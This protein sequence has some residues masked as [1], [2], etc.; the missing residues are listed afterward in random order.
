MISCLKQRS[1]IFHT[2]HHSGV[3]AFR[4][5]LFTDLP[6]KFTLKV[7]GSWATHEAHIPKSATDY[8]Y[9]FSDLDI[10]TEREVDRFC[11]SEIKATIHNVAYK[12]KI[13]LNN[14]SVRKAV[15]IKELWNI[16]RYKIQGLDSIDADAFLGFW[17]IIGAI[18]AAILEKNC[19]GHPTSPTS[20][21]FA[22]FFLKFLNNLCVI[23]NYF[24]NCYYSAA[25][26]M[27]RKCPSPE[28]FLAYGVKT[29]AITELSFDSANQLLSSEFLKILHSL[30]RSRETEQMIL[31]VFNDVFKWHV[32]RK[33][34]PVDSY[35]QI[36]YDL[37]TSELQKNVLTRAYQKFHCRKF[38]HEQ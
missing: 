3:T 27:S 7:S 12:S 16:N 24:P 35:L 31:K 8:I 14:I 13:L 6:V 22:K 9:S 10:V 23:N 36:G 28:I 33:A 30:I 32:Y 19:G 18:E 26:F 21:G 25:I 37:A 11:E 1:V 15:E 29:G 5:F 17:T 38:Q 20:Y 34:L 2:R 4:N